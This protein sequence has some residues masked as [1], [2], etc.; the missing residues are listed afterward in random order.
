MDL[1]TW[2]WTPCANI[3]ARM[4]YYYY[5]TNIRQC[6]TVAETLMLGRPGSGGYVVFAGQTSGFLG[7]GIWVE[8]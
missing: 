7:A 1:W 8:G 2:I 5:S 3:A 4:F 6:G